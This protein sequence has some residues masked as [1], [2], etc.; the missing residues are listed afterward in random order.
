MLCYHAVSPTWDATLAVSPDS[1]ERQLTMLR[2]RGWRG[3]TF[4][5]AV[6]DPPTERT[7]A[8]TF[9]DAFASVCRLAYPILASLGLPGTVF[10]P[11]AFVSAGRP[12]SWAGIEHWLQTP[13]AT[14]LQSMSWEELGHL[15]QEGWEIGSHTRTHPHLT[16]LDEPALRTELE[17]S[18]EE[19]ADH[20]GITCDTIAY[21]YGNVD[22]RV[23][24][25]AQ[26]AGYMAG[27]ALS[28]PLTP[29]GPGRWP[30]I[31]VYHRD[32]MWRFRLKANRAVRRLRAGRYWPTHPET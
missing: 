2:R 19:I 7:L 27:A 21:P 22:S 24:Q 32:A 15:A 25:A 17:L 6:L 18:R 1:L 16:E 10:A 14:E 20:L 26:T 3:A 8:V 29:L 13:S 4:R 9:D 5:Q 31:G 12:L 11:S 28:G 23:A 30:R